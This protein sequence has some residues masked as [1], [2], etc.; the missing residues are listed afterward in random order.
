MENKLIF[1]FIKQYHIISLIIIF[2]NFDVLFSLFINHILMKQLIKTTGFFY[3]IVFFSM[4]ISTMGYTQSV[5]TPLSSSTYDIIERFDIKYPEYI[6]HINTTTKPYK[7]K[8]IIHFINA[9]T[10][11]SSTCEFTDVDRF[12]IVY[13]LK[14]N[15]EWHQ[16]ILSLSKRQLIKP[17]YKEQ[18]DLYSIETD[19]Y[20]FKVSPVIHFDIG[21]E[22]GSNENKYFNTRGLELR[23]GINNKVGFYSFLADN[24]AILPAYV[25]RKRL[26]QDNVLSGEGWQQ[27]FKNTGTDF[28]TARGYITFNATKN[29]DV[30]FGQDKNFLANGYRS[31]QLSDYSNNYLFLKINSRIGPIHYQ[32]LFC[33][34][35]DYPLQMPQSNLFKKKYATTHK[36]DVRIFDNLHF[37][38]FENIVFA[39]GDSG[40]ST[41]GF[42]FHY[43]N[44]VIFYRAVEHHLGDNDNVALGIDWKYNFLKRFSFYGQ[45]FIDEFNF[46]D[47]KMDIDSFLVKIKLKSQRS[48]TTQASFRNK[49]GFQTGLKYI[50]V[51]GIDN[52]DAQIELNVVRP[53][54]YTHYDVTYSGKPPGEIYSHYKQPLAHPNGANFKELIIILKYQ[55]IFPLYITAKYFGITQGLDSAGTNYGSNIFLDYE[56][57]QKDY[58]NTL[59]QGVQTRIQLADIMVSYQLKHNIFT[60]LRYIYRMEKSDIA[61]RDNKTSYITLGL[62]MNFITRKFD[63]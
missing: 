6:R 37:G 51:A 24:Q 63:F 47:L 49:F 33:E 36:L 56:T 21:K 15:S 31:L 42:D 8:D 9:I 23:A 46:S 44:P 7:R 60:D 27:T 26:L 34:L 43:L 35:I 10:N 32:N 57:R 40:A 58:G 3:S 17:F 53:Y 1:L 54:V 30:Q 18:A 16:N 2:F 14:D 52:L 29:I 19:D 55:P 22:N 62:R 45:V 61:S 38:F 41:G 11:D 13:L 48:Y 12:N 4:L 39:R 5:Y 28:F 50:D 20:M 59:C 25:N